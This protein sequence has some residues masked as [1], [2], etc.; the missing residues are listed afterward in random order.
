MAVQQHLAALQ[1]HA[2]SLHLQLRT[3]RAPNADDLIEAFRHIHDAID[4][5]A[6]AV[7]GLHDNR[8]ACFEATQAPHLP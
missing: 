2:Q 6:Q 7:Q 8:N 5:L 1:Q 3:N 4:E